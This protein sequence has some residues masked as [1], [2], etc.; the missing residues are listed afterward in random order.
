MAATEISSKLNALPVNAP[1]AY[2]PN[3]AELAE[4]NRAT[5]EEVSKVCTFGEQPIGGLVVVRQ[6]APAYAR[7]RYKVVSNPIGLDTA[8][9]ALFCDGGSLCFG[10]RMGAGS[11]IEVYTD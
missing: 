3:Y 1:W 4:Q 5:Y 6:M 8:H 2:K 10:Y 7:A 11:V 9:I